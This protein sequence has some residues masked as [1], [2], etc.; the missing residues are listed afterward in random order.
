LFTSRWEK[1]PLQP[2]LGELEQAFINEFVR[3]RG[4]DP[5]HLGSLPEHV[6]ETL[7]RDASVY[8]SGRLTEV[9]ARSHFC[10]EIHHGSDQQ[11]R[12]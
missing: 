5:D 3:A 11:H 12:S 4:Y 2:P 8:A 10:D 6:L 7:L 9:E 1:A